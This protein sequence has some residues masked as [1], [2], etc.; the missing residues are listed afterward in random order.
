MREHSIWTK[1]LPLG[2]SFSW[3]VMSLASG[4]LPL[5]YE[6]HGTYIENN[7]NSVNLRR[8]RNWADLQDVRRLYL[9]SKVRTGLILCECFAI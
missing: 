8:V 7:I 3:A 1:P 5:Q 6:V 9:V 2:A 4:G